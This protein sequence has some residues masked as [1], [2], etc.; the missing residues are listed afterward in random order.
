MTA[1]T[2]FVGVRVPRHALALALL[3]E[4]GVPIAAPSAN[5][6]GHVSPTRARHVFEDL[7][8]HPIGLLDA[9]GDLL[10][11]FGSDSS[12]GPSD[13]TATAVLPSAATPA[14]TE[15]ASSSSS[16]SSSPSSSSPAPAASCEVGIEST[17]LR[18]DESGSS[19]T[20]F[21]PGGVSLAA[22]DSALRAAGLD[23]V[24][25]HVLARTVSAGHAPAP[26]SSA[27]TSSSSSSSSS[28][29]EAEDA[30]AEDDDGPGTP[31][32]VAPGQL[33]T[34]YAPDVPT[35]LLHRETV[36]ASPSAG[37]S[38][39][40]APSSSA[41]ASSSAFSVRLSETVVLDFG[42]WLRTLPGLA[43]TALAYRDLAPSSSVEEA[44]RGLF[45]ALRWAEQVEGAKAV[46]VVDLRE[47]EAR[48]PSADLVSLE[49]L[50]DRLFRAA[51]GR[52][53]VW[54]EDASLAHESP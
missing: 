46:V 41:S 52:T 42:G 16:S 21:R 13:G 18:I 43:D 50:R 54:R 31:G 48:A 47:V 9:E 30:A 38:L 34:H 29:S 5:R 35:Y 20:V 32:E 8:T 10:R 15:D 27:A 26:A 44:Q 36:S 45:E 12:S 39:P 24:R 33:L 25:V 53:L 22:I 14:T 40:P 3:R 17:V 2:G 6:F 19:L 4:A 11:E 37:P 7:G 51:S 1:D 28:S 23:D 49:G